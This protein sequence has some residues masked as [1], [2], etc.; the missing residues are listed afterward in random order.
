MTFVGSRLLNTGKFTVIKIDISELKIL[1]G[2]HL[3][4]MAANTGLT[5]F[6]SDSCQSI[7]GH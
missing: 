4:E 7:F 5:A 3:I 6:I 1:T 2:G